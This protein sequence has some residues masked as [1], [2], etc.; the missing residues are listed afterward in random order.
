MK[1][2]ILLF[3]LFTV[4]YSSYS[5]IPEIKKPVILTSSHRVSLEK[6]QGLIIFKRKSDNHIFNSSYKI[7]ETF[8]NTNTDVA[9]SYFSSGLC[10]EGRFVKGYKHGLWTT[11][12]NTKRVKTTNWNN[13]LIIGKYRV[14]DTEG[15]YLYETTFG[16]QG[17]G[18]YKDYYYLSGVLKEEGNY[19]NGKKEGEW[20]YYD[21]K[22]NIKTTA[23]YENGTPIKK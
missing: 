9:E 22:G 1:H 19:E 11:T 18:K 21:E 10:W 7:Y 6:I 5:Q 3:I 20:C 8:L 4:T 17:N 13:G 12:Y 16:T 14:Y 15:K 23:H 2:K